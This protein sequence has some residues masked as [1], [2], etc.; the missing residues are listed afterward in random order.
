MLINKFRK[1]LQTKYKHV[2]NDASY[3]MV[4]NGHTV[5]LYFEWSNGELD[6]KNNFDFPAKPYRDMEN[7]WFCH[8]GFLKVWKSIEPH[9]ADTI[10]DPEVRTID[11]V[12]YSHGGAIAQLCYE[13]VKFNRPDVK[14]E[15]VGFG[16]PRVFWGFA[17]KKVMERFKGFE[18]IRVGN[19][20]VTHLPPVI[21]GFRH[22]G[23]VIKLGESV[24][25]IKDHYPSRYEA[26]LTDFGEFERGGLTKHYEKVLIFKSR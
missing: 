12:G 22:V 2:D 26:V 5:H 4:R 16:A 18:I 13:Y 20:L 21:F 23:T 25:P 6:W 3:S 19:D 9:I 11:I 15:G 17:N 1:C 8:R 10:N 24:G 14:V 7:T